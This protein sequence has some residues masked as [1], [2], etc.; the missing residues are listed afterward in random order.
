MK[1]LDF[2]EHNSQ[3]SQANGR[4]NGPRDGHKRLTADIPAELH[5]R[6]KLQA[7]QEECTV[8]DIII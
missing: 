5:K 7:L 1:Q 2:V 6:L 3:K 8:T 4:S